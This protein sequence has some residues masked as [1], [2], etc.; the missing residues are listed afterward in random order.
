MSDRV[1]DL[2]RRDRLSWRLMGIALACACAIG[3]VLSLGQ[4]L[5]DSRSQSAEIDRSVEHLLAMMR[6]PASEAAY[7]IDD[8]LA[9]R[10]LDGLFQFDGVI[11][12]ELT[13]GER[14]QL[15]GHE[16][17]AQEGSFR[18]VTKALF[19]ERRDY[20][21]ALTDPTG[22]AVGTLSLQLDTYPPGRA[23]L[24]R[25]AFVV[26]AGILRAGLFA[27]ML[28]AI[29]HLFLTRPLARMAHT[30][31]AF[32]PNS[33]ESMHL[34]TPR[35]H[36]RDELG[37]W[38]QGVN[39][40]LAAIRE[41]Q[42]RRAEAETRAAYLEHFDSL[43]GIANRQLLLLRA[44]HAIATP[45]ADLQMAMLIVD[46]R[47]FRDINA[48]YGNT[49][50][51]AVLRELAQRLQVI[52]ADDSALAARLADDQF[53]LLLRAPQAR[54]RA[55]GLAE[56][57]LVAFATP[58]PV[59]SQQVPLQL[60]IGIAVFP[61]DAQSAEQLVQNAERALAHAKK[62]PIDPSQFYQ[63]EQDKELQS[64]KRL[65][66]DLRS[67]LQQDEISI[68][69]QPI[70]AAEGGQ[71]VAV[72]ALARWRH[73]VL[74]DIPP[75]QFVPL[76]EA[77][78]Q[79]LAIGEWVLRE[80]CRHAAQWQ[81]LRAKPLRIAVNVSATQLRDRGFEL[82]VESALSAARLPPSLLELEITET[83]IIENIDQAIGTL[84]RVRAAGVR[85]SVDDFGTGHA[86]LNYLKRLPIDQLKIDLSFI[87]DLLHDPDDAQIVKAIINLGHSLDLEVVAEGVEDMAQLDFLEANQCD[88][89]QGFL[90]KRPLPA[91]AFTDYLQRMSA[92]AEAAVP[93]N[94]RLLR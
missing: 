61:D 31:A 75:V 4:I 11:R 68:H 32:D 84:E 82:V 67:A 72:E 34:Q 74:G 18:F 55:A 71:V 63:A 46:V 27:L 88:L 19:G 48:Q 35:R 20:R 45:A 54:E 66:R 93:I 17:A 53:A 2:P 33:P 9:R 25:A 22:G 16:R 92:I 41:N 37:Q 39:R 62:Q 38:A 3:V 83:A 21:M 49:F 23:F 58:L 7:N 14:E 57:V 64:R 91:A 65:A 90:L 77:G 26:V 44:M 12:A 40:L 10:V 6:E 76:A 43:T 70:V 79:I 29:F 24:D 52:A 30:L 5:L 47:E 80:A 51:D 81:R 89:V 8:R 13:V 59:G 73:P 69:Y 15:A 85:I 56:R 78:G 28:L 42:S 36:E 1:P 87:R 86:S 60:K 50:G 94:A